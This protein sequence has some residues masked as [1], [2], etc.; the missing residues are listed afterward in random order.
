MLALVPALIAVLLLGI[1]GA[2][3]AGASPVPTSRV[4][5]PSDDCDAPLCPGGAQ[6][7]TTSGRAFHCF[8][9]QLSLS[10]YCPAPV[11]IDNDF[12]C[13]YNSAGVLTG[14]YNPGSTGSCC[15]STASKGTRPVRVKARSPEPPQ[16]ESF[17]AQLRRRVDHWRARNEARRSMQENEVGLIE[18]K[19]RSTSDS[20]GEKRD[21]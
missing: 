20:N 15:P 9:S 1:K 21:P 2:T 4:C 16:P 19:E 3:A 5:P 14:G 7:P 8:Y 18:V 13:I 11:N 12:H 6:Y 17:P 10:T